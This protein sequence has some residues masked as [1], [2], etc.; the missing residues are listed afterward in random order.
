MH[1]KKG[2]KFALVVEL[3]KLNY[4]YITE[5]TVHTKIAKAVPG[6]IE[7]LLHSQMNQPEP[8]F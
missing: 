5:F 2:L 3:A 4:T 6:T 8:N 1:K 7:T